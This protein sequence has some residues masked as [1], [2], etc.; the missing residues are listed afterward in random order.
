MLTHDE[1]LG[2]LESGVVRGAHRANVNAA[3]IDV[4]LGSTLLVEASPGGG[5]TVV[6][7]MAKEVPAMRRIDLLHAGCRRI[8]LLH[9][10]CYDLR[11]GEFCLA[12][13][14]ER[15]YLPNNL[16]ANYYLKSSLARAGLDAALAMW[17][18]PGWNA[19]VLTLELVNNLRH[20]SLRL[21]PGMKIG[22]MVFHRGVE[23]PDHASYAVRGR[24]N[25]DTQVQASKGVR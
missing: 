2:L 1:L 19:S 18:D 24:Y 21:R 7:L 22:Q 3:S 6:D 13:T 17:A 4:V 25:G 16:A 10:G 8:D 20:H 5:S 14:V 23:V 9:A 11:P 15:F 12:E